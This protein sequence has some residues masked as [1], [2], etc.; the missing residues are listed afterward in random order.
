MEVVYIVCQVVQ[1]LAAL[2][3]IGLV[4][5]QQGKGAEMGAAMGSSAGGVSASLFGVAGSANLL[6]RMTAAAATC[7]FMATLGLAYMGNIKHQAV[8]QGAVQSPAGGSVFDRATPSLPS[9]NSGESKQSDAKNSVNE[10]PK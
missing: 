4:L 3:V 8:K 2:M 10:I 6:S 7:F 9:V 1:V 5:L